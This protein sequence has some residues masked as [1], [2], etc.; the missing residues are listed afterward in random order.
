M[1]LLDA[2]THVLEAAREAPENPILTRAIKRL[3][4]RVQLLRLR[5]AKARRRNRHKAWNRATI[6]FGASHI[7]CVECKCTIDFGT[8]AKRALID[9]RGRAV[10]LRCP[11]CGAQVPLL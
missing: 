9:G 5:A 8:F 7:G 4:R 6:P 2:T 3:D 1:N 10:E 11:E